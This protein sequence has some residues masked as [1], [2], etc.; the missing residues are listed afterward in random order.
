MTAK[1]KKKIKCAFEIGRDDVVPNSYNNNGHYIFR[2]VIFLMVIFSYVT[3]TF[4]CVNNTPKHGV[5][6]PK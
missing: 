2:H 6:L 1:K 3:N 4:A 5:R